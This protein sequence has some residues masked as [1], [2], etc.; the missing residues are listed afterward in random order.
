[1][2]LENKIIQQLQQFSPIHLRVD[3]ESDMHAGPPNRETHFRVEMVAEAFQGLSR[4]RRHQ[5]IYG[6]FGDDFQAGLHALSLHLYAPD[7]WQ[8]HAPQSPQCAG[9]H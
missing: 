9:N 2:S 1:M 6:L 4:V 8:G 3:N 5:L 7:E